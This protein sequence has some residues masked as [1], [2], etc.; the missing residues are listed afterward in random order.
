MENFVVSARK[1]RPDVFSSVIGQENITRTIKNSVINKQIAHAYLFCGPRGVGKTTCA[2]I[3]AKVINCLNPSSDYEPCNECD[4][5]TAFNRAGSFN[6]HEL[7][8]ASNN[9][10]DDIRSLIE[11][12]RIP[13]QI[14]K[15]SV[16][17]IDEVHMLSSNAFN[18]FL[19]TLEEPPAHAVFILATTEKH[20][21]LP[22]ILSRCQ[23][24]DFSRISVPDIVSRL[25]FV[26]QS[27]GVKIDSDAL[28]VIAQ[29]ADGA[30][31]DALSIFD[32]IVS[33]SGKEITYEMVLKNLN[34]LD[35][36][37]YFRMTDLLYKGNIP[38]ALIELDEI[39]NRGF[40]PQYF[41]AGLIRH[42]RDLMI[43][44]TPETLALLEVGDNFRERYRLQA[45][46]LPLKFIYKAIEYC[47]ECDTQYKL[48]SSKRLLVELTL[49]RISGENG[50][51]N[52]TPAAV[53]PQNNV[54]SAT[55]EQKKNEPSGRNVKEESV[56]YNIQSSEPVKAS[57]ASNDKQP[58]QQVTTPAVTRVSIKQIAQETSANAEIQAEEQKKEYAVFDLESVKKFWTEFAEKVKTDS[59]AI[60]ASMLN[61]SPQ[62]DAEGKI[63]I[64]IENDLQKNEYTRHLDHI[65]KAL[66][67]EFGPR[68][69]DVVF[70]VTETEVTKTV[71]TDSD[72]MKYFSENY[73]YF[74][75]FRGRF[76]LEVV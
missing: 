37:Y 61:Q 63:V 41:I 51:M 2:R 20:K 59:P 6:I 60:S 44:R 43:S 49:L 75:D 33:F 53:T 10:V 76:G 67:A 62:L 16:Y 65:R 39:I 68:V 46:Q 36:E 9:S 29:K 69:Y 11:K 21:I 8:A 50:A 12:V 47:N 42:Y 3:F 28:N 35:F 66:A 4:S 22:T 73:P 13:P 72:K 71:F 5:C 32:Q 31:R 58:P 27:E 74:N 24:Y 54:N 19:K 18:A 17:I 26:A 52:E 7:D 1:Y 45:Q 57:P 23:V 38:G 56:G 70:N 40:E 25:S 48:S 55:T 15:Y 14:G 30:L 64:T 34:V